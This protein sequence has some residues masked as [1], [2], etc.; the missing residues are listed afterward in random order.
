MKGVIFNVVEEV[1][2]AAYGPE[3]W[4]ALLD[5]AGVE[6][7]YTSLG[8]YPDVELVKLVGAASDTTGIAPPALLKLVGR[9]ALPRLKHRYPGFFTQIGDARSFILSLNAIIHPEVRKLYAGAG[10]PH[11]QF[12]QGEGELVLGYNS[13]RK[14]CH[15]AEGLAAGVA[16]HY[17]ETVEISQ[18]ACMHDGHPA[19]HIHVRWP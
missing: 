8:S 11:F 19:C 12:T 15:L 14:L 6:G 10:C 2:A 3:M 17:G 9:M 4:E 7:I 18:S 5:K 1:V 16:D 13:A